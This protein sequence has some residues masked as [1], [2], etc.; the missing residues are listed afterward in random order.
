MLSLYM[1]EV[2]LHV[3]KTD[4]LRPPH[5]TE[6]LGDPIPG[7]SESL[8][9]AH[10]SAL[11]SCL[12]AIDGIFEVFL[13]M[14]VRSIRCLPVFNFVRVAYA[15]VVL[16]KMYF[17]AKSPDSDLGKVIDKDNM[18]VEEYLEKLLD[19][20]RAVADV[21]KSRPAAKFMLVLAM[22][23]GW[24]Q[25]QG[26]I[27][28]QGQ[29][30]GQDQAQKQTAQPSPRGNERAASKPDGTTA[31]TTT[32]SGPGA[33][34]PPPPPP[35][36]GPQ[37]QSEYNPANTPL[38][39][40]SEIAT[41]NDPSSRAK[42]QNGG[43]HPPPPPPMGSMPSYQQPPFAPAPLGQ[44]HQ[45]HQHPPPSMYNGSPDVVMGGQQP[46]QQ[47]Q[48]PQQP[49]PTPWLSQG[50]TDFDFDDPGDG[51]QQAMGL[52]LQGLGSGPG[53]TDWESTMR[54]VVHGGGGI[55]NLQDWT[56]I[57]NFYNE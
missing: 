57:S 11:S 43:A 48:P 6:G 24:F 17:S 25:K 8:T 12:T 26:E 49:M 42:Q 30:Q 23:R 7:L 29:T 37:K 13:S 38:Q 33:G 54:Q 19:K 14:D 56:G 2:A 4:D 31:T 40:L 46:Q 52:T 28:G 50:W 1:H 3:D 47:P 22:L 34:A 10:I 39:L 15:T 41:G 36:G 16:I 9:T 44:Q 45:H 20:F 27:Q 35:S 53:Y 5:S 18:K 51:F 55:G 21:D 32:G